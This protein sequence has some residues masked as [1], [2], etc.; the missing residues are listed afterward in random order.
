M[1]TPELVGGDRKC[2]SWAQSKIMRYTCLNTR[3]SAWHRGPSVSV[4]AAVP[5]ENQSAEV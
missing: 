2:R 4:S 1:G 5:V 3:S